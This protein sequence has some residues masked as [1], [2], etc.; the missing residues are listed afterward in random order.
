M[1]TLSAGTK[2]PE[3]VVSQI[4]TEVQGK[5]TVAKLANAMPVSVLLP[6]I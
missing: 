1:A 4:F 3:K 2:F 6:T 5:S